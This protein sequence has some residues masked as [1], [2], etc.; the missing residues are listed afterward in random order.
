MTT[1]F[2]NIRKYLDYVFDARSFTP[3]FD[4]EAVSGGVLEA[5]RAIRGAGRGPAIILHGIMP[6]SGTVYAGELLRLHPD[7]QAYPNQIWE[8]PLLQLTGDVTALQEKFLWAYRHNAGKLGEKDFM[9]LLGAAFVG[10]LHAF[11][12]QG[13][14]VLLK[15]PG[16][17]YLSGFF[18]MFPHENLL[19]LVRDGRDVVH[20]TVKTWPQIRFSLACLRYRRSAGMVH[21]CHARYRDRRQGYWLA[22]FEDAVEDPASFVRQACAHFDLDV[23]RY[24]FDQIGT[25]P[26]RGSSRVNESAEVTWHPVERPPDFNPVGRWEDWSA[27]QKWRFKRI[28]GPALVDLGY[29]KDLDW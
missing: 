19:V 25:L 11:V 23:D 6:R 14:R 1:L 8:A 27:W 26:V 17:H 3:R 16:V 4:P 22:R 15:V 13:K 28:A 24:P 12:P 9:T 10:Y 29:C 7:L 2:D 20:S 18:T 5:A 21:A